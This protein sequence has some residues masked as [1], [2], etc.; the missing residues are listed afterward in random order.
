MTKD[1]VKRPALPVDPDNIMPGAEP[2]FIDQG[3]V[4]ILFLHG[5]TGST[6]EG[7]DF[8]F[9]FAQKGYAVWVPLLPGHG[10]SPED[11]ENIDYTEWL[12][13]SEKYYLSMKEQ[14]QKVFVCGQSMGGALALHLATK[15][16]IDGVI[17]LAGAIIL[18]DWRLKLL[19]LAKR[20][21]RYQYKSKGPDIR[22]K[23]AKQKSASYHKYPIKSLVQFLELLDHV[24]PKL[25]RVECPCLLIH[26]RRDHTITYSNLDYISRHI[27][28][29]I[30][31]TLTLENSYHVISVDEEKGLILKPVEEFLHDI[32]NPSSHTPSQNPSNQ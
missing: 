8:G 22:S 29:P 5:F 3:K 24:K 25:S 18:K 2:M 30:L 16:S 13:V 14:Y 27:S 28:S 26:S 6:Y 12:E 11:L 7:R 1:M 15:Y 23:E 17:S 32:L 19:P 9:Y 10:T 4:G 31:R 20:V 21:I